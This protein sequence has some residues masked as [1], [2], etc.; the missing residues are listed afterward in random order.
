M[1]E[2]IFKNFS[3]KLLS[4]VFAVVL[5]TV[6]VNIY[7]PNTSYTFSNITVQLINTQSLTDKITVMKL[8]MA[9]RFQLQ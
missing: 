5:W 4:A 6:I 2:K 9:A 1:K 8:L 3:L 7:D